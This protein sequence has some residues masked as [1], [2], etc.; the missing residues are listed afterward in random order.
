MFSLVDL[1]AIFPGFIVLESFASPEE[2]DS[3]KKRMD[4]LLDEFDFSTTA[5]I[6]S[7]KNQVLNQSSLSNTPLV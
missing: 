4:Q 1:R 5:S 3:L 2:V 7:T 6:F